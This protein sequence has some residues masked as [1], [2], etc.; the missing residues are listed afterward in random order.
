MGL[1][2]IIILM[3]LCSTAFAKVQRVGNVEKIKEKIEMKSLL[4]TDL[5]IDKMDKAEVAEYLK[6]IT[7]ILEKLLED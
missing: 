2:I 1:K 3:V 7:D 6:T 5:A 4:A